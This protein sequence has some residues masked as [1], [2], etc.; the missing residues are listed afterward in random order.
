MKKRYII[1]RILQVLPVA[2]GVIVFIFL[3]LHSMPGDFTSA[4]L[5]PEASVEDVERIREQYGLNENVFVQLINY[6]RQL[7]TFDFG[8]SIIFKKPVSEMISTAFPATLEM[9]IMGMVWALIIAVPLGILSAVKQ[10][11]WIDNISMVLAQLGIS[12]PVFW[13][14]LLMILL[15]SVK[16]NWLPSFGRG[17]AITEAL[18]LGFTTGSFAQLSNSFKKLLM[19]SF[20]LGIMG[21]A[22]ISRMIR[23]TMLE[24][25]DMDYIRT[26]RAKGTAEIK[27]VMK[28]AFRNALPPV[29]TIVALQF[30]ALLGGSIVTETVFS[31]PGIG[32]V[33]V[34]AILNRDYPV[35]QAGVFIIAIMFVGINL[36]VDLMYAVINPKIN[37]G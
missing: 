6:M 35:V 14:G 37:E 22:M 11:S 12:M 23:S 18:N 4:L 31:W 7:V 16:L 27:V 25:L 10:N 24:V 33:L 34:T 9:A 29:L 26:A 19:P 17:M 8:D 32:Q 30:G 1:K 13:M 3:L 2:I 5:G 15:F 21:A 28:H 20:A 36:V